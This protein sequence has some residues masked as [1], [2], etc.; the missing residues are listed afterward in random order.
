VLR[1]KGI[2]RFCHHY[3]VVEHNPPPLGN[4]NLGFQRL[5]QAADGNYWL[6]ERSYAPTTRIPLEAR[7]WPRGT[8]AVGGRGLTGLNAGFLG[9]VQVADTNVLH[10]SADQQRVL[11]ATLKRAIDADRFP[12]SPRDGAEIDS[13]AAG[14]AGSRAGSLPRCSTSRHLGL[15]QSSGGRGGD[16]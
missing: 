5:Y 12:L 4:Q 8:G 10:L 15:R 1:H 6:H 11:I 14:T 13:G 2:T 7:E 16:G 3:D 9:S